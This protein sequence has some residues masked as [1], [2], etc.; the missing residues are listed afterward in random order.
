[1]DA[2]KQILNLV[3]VPEREEHY[4]QGHIM[5]A[6]HCTL[7]HAFHRT[8][9]HT[10]TIVTLCCCPMSKAAELAPRDC[11][12]GLSCMGKYYSMLVA[13]HTWQQHETDV[14]D[15]SYKMTTPLLREP[16]LH[17]CIDICDE[18]HLSHNACS[19]ALPCATPPLLFSRARG[20]PTV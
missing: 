18:H 9:F 4:P 10:G 2:D 12:C 8:H 16:C 17:T 19:W 6:R 1:M 15:T 5:A 7:L 11:S 3:C 20:F 13:N 14:F